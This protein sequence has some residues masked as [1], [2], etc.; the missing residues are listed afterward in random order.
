LDRKSIKVKLDAAAIQKDLNEAQSNTYNDGIT[1]LLEKAKTAN[2]PELVQ[3]RELIDIITNYKKQAA[4]LREES[5]TL[6]SDAAK[7]GGLSNAEEKELEM[8][9]KQLDVIGLLRKYDPEFVIKEPSVT[10]AA[11]SDNASPE[12]K[13]KHDD[14]LQKQVVEYDNINKANALE[15]ETLNSQLPRNLDPQQSTAK[16]KAEQ[17]ITESKDLTAKASQASD[18]KQ[19]KELLSNAANKGQEAVATLNSITASA[20]VARNN[21]PR[22]NTPRNNRNNNTGGNNTGGNE[23]NS[24]NTAAANNTPR[25]NRNNTTTNTTPNTNAVAIKANGVEVKTTNAYSGANPIPIDQKIPDGLVFRVQIGAFKTPVANDAFKGLAPVNGQTT[26]NGYIRYTAGNFEKFEDANAVKNDLNNLGYKDAF[27]VGY[28]NGKRVSLSEIADILSKEG[29][30]VDLAAN[31]NQSAGITEN[32]N[33]PRNTAPVAVN[34]DANTNPVVVTKELEQINGMLFTIQIGVYTRQI[35]KSRL[36]NLAPIYTEKLPSGLY[37]YT[38]G[39]YN[40]KQLLLDHRQKVAD[41]GIKDAFV[42]AYYNG[43]KIT[44]ADAERLKSDS[45]NLKMEP[46][47]PIVFPTNLQAN[48]ATPVPVNPTNN[49]PTGNV[50]PFTNN[51]TSGPEPTAE[52]GVKVGEA[53]LTFKV[54]I[55]AYRNQVPNETAAKFLNIKTW[56]IVNKQINGLFIYTVGNFVDAASAKK[57]KNEMVALGI[58]DAYVTVYRDGTKLYGTEA[59]GLLNR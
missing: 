18:A 30:P 55:G 41:I 43:K 40:Q 35:S 19:K 44:F 49:T 26:P 25:N 56:P 13:Q 34:N 3:V 45:A 42:S 31:S 32:A 1:S 37:R 52:N 38:A 48:N 4:N 46:E 50:A 33:I 59:A 10:V 47:N 8:F 36:Y 51:V 27:V 11:T 39:I 9:N 57:L 28:Y 17:L 6:P 12:L 14:V 7:L 23:T 29:K 20:T 16:Q 53:G 24:G 15:Y 58:N 2:A 22:N 5:A 21:T 54:Q